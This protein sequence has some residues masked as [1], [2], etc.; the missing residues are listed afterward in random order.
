MPTVTKAPNAAVILV[1]PDRQSPPMFIIKFDPSGMLE[2]RIR[3]LARAAMR[4]TGAEHQ[5]VA[6]CARTSRKE[7]RSARSG[8]LYA[9]WPSLKS[10]QTIPDLKTPRQPAFSKRMKTEGRQHI[11]SHRYQALEA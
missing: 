4:V 11:P 6:K 2:P 7:A 9:Y 8:L 1:V 10:I 3:I 5:T